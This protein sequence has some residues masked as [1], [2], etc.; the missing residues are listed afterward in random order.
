MKTKKIE[1][2]QE[3]PASILFLIISKYLLCK[4]MLLWLIREFK[5]KVPASILLWIVVVYISH[6]CSD[7]ETKRQR[8]RERKRE[9]E[10][11]R[12]RELLIIYMQIFCWKYRI[13]ACAIV[14]II[15]VIYTYT[16]IIFI[17]LNIPRKYLVSAWHCR[18]PRGPFGT[19]NACGRR[20]RWPRAS[21]TS[22]FIISYM[23]M[24]VFPKKKMLGS[25]RY[26][27]RLRT[28]RVL[29]SCERT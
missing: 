2:I 28:T 17:S 3:E 22:V 4:Y 21:T 18:N 7:T 6:L 23:Y 24:I 9:R 26:S 25:F 10:R 29:C 12:E 14:E 13:G 5:K 19:L 27:L 20:E 11:E 8:E 1:T 15:G 16:F